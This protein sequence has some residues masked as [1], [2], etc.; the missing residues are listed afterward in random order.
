VIGIIFPGQNVLLIIGGFFAQISH[1]NLVW[2]IVVTSVSAIIGN[3][4]G[5]WM[6]TKWG[7]VFFEKY[8]MWFGIGETEIKY[9]EK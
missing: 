2:V 5:Y 6:G 8:G 9:L 7:K 4:I 3:Y 1:W